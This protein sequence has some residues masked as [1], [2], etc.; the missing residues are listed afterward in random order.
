MNPNISEDELTI[1]LENYAKALEFNNARLNESEY[2]SDCSKA[3]NIDELALA[4]KQFGKEFVELY[5]NDGDSSISF[6]EMLYR[7]I[8][9]EYKPDLVELFK[10]KRKSEEEAERL[11]SITAEKKAL[12]VVEKYCKDMNNLP[13]LNTLGA[14]RDYDLVLKTMQKFSV[15]DAAAA[16][17]GDEKITATE[18]AAHLMSMAQLDD[19]KNNISSREFQYTKL[20]L[21]FKDVPETE[22]IE[23]L[24]SEGL[25]E[26]NAKKL[27]KNIIT[28][29][30]NYDA[31]M[32]AYTDFLTK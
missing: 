2:Q 25:E 26:E 30:Q 16:G 10:K 28:A 19:A 13:D 12:E 9:D 8:L 15:L 27:A 32:K 14:Q 29:T 6:D 1:R 11:A 4:Y 20:I 18:A 7:E 22:I 31:R 3:K 24:I 17:Q 5:D 21:K 23:T